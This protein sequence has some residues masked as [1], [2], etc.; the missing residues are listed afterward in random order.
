MFSGGTLS[1]TTS[2]ELNKNR[3][4]TVG[5]ANPVCIFDVTPGKT[6]TYGGR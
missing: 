1:A 6:L 4:V 2:F 3:G 5:A